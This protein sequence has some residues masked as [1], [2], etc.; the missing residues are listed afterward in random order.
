VAGAKEETNPGHDEASKTK[1]EEA[2]SGGGGS[3]LL[4][5]NQIRWREV[6]EEGELRKEYLREGG[7]RRAK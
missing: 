7:S 4:S 5:R 2:D 3:R 6:P 1:K